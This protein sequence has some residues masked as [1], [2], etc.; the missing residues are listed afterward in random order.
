MTIDM[1]ASGIH[2]DWGQLEIAIRVFYSRII[3]IITQ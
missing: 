2:K 1:V 3:I